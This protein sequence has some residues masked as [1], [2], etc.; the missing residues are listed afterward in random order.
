MRI[1]WSGAV[2]V[3]ALVA[4]CPFA[5]TSALAQDERVATVDSDVIIVTAQRRQEAQVDVPISITNISS[6]ALATANVTGLTDISKVSPGLRF[7]STGGGFVQPSIRGIG[8]AVTTSGGGANVGIYIDGFYSPNPLAADFDLLSVESIQ[9]LKGPQG[10]LF[11]R[12]TTGGAILVQTRD[13]STAGNSLEGKIRYGR[14]NELKAQSFGNVAISDRVAM[15]VEGLYRRGDGWVTD[16]SSGNKKAGKF[17]NWSVRLGMKAELTDD[18]SLLLRWKHSENDDPKANLTARSFV[19]SEFGLGAPFGGIPGTYTT[20]PNE[21]ATGSVPEFFKSNSDVLQATLEADLGFANFTSY[22]QYRNENVDQ[23]FD[24]DYSAV[25]IFQ[26]GLPVKDETWSQEFLLNSKPGSPLQW[27]AGAFYFENTDTYITFIDSFGYG[28]NQRIRLGGS[29]TT[30][31]S[32]AA[33]FDGT[34]EVVPKLFV[35]AG[36]RYAYDKIDDAY[37]N[38]R[39]LAPTLDLGNGTTIA[40]KDGRVYL[41]DYDPGAVKFARGDRLTPRFVVRY[42]PNDEMSVYASY[43]QGYKAAI[44]D[45]GGTC[46]TPPYQCSRVKPEKISAYEVGFKYAT[47]GLSFETAAFYYDYK[48]LQVSIYRAGTAELVNAAKSEIYGLEGQLNYQVTPAFKL[49]AGASYVHARYKTFGQVLANGEV[50]GAPIYKFCPAPAGAKYA[51]ACGPGRTFYVNTDT[52]LKNVPMQ[53]TPEFTGFLGANYATDLAGGTFTLSGN[54]YYTSSYYFGPSGTQFKQKG[55][56]TLSLRA[57]W[58]DPSETYSVALWGDNVT[59]SRYRTQITYGDF[60][61]GSA[62]NDP[63]TYGIELGFKFK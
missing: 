7:D 22:S 20:K 38:T 1:V 24:L 18:V 55:F 34:Y 5:A 14:F 32:Y 45:V 9:V 48:D 58:T 10:T 57:E 39:F 36:L 6:S 2:S 49:M 28:P 63:V 19:D 29:A 15:S 16:I 21:I 41:R 11:G 44:L 3:L 4:V 52:I 51:D 46:Q 40:A 33:F 56:E 61:I 26:F 17:E 50:Q 27:T 37:F 43:T 62:Y 13:P 25:E 8:T 47:H 53:R 31:R 59:D 35:T 42:K 60:G 12:N 30:V 54:L 23:S